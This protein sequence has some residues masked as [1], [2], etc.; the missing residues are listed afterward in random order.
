MLPNSLQPKVTPEESAESTTKDDSAQAEEYLAGWQ[1]AKADYA[2][3]K[4]ESEAK[5]LELTRYANQELLH[6]LLPLVDYFK[7]ALRAVPAA[8]A[9][10][11]W[12]DGIRHIQTRLLEVL[13]Y[14]GVKEMDTVGEK[15]SPELHEAVQEVE[16]AGQPPGTVVEEVRTGFTLYD[17]VLQPARVKVAK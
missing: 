6:E 16:G 5:L 12:V 13:A 9:S 7:Q 3:L 4:R 14:H 15:F 2:N 8:E 1:R 10:S 11:P 17:R